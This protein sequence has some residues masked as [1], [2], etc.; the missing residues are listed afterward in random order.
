MDLGKT[1]GI[2]KYVF[3]IAEIRDLAVSALVLGF[4][5]AFRDW[6]LANFLIAVAVV[7]PALILHELAHKFMAQK[8]G[9]VAAYVVWPTG[10]IISVLITIMTNGAVIFAALGAVMISSV[11]HTRLGYQFIGLTSKEMGRISWVGPMT[12]IGLAIIS[13]ILIPLNPAVFQLSAF[14]NIIIAIFNCLPFPPL[15]G[16]KIFRWNIPIWLGTLATALVLM[17]LPGV[18]GLLYSL[19]IAAILVAALFFWLQLVMPQ[20][21][22]MQSEYR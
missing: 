20:T 6:S 3:T 19:I 13:Y 17:F 12:N 8:Y 14:I 15:D 22:Q 5:F 4:I 10:I 2:G 9:L 11:Y 16:V 18:V 1:I 21:Q 7:G